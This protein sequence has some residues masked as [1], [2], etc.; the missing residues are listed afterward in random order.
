MHM[1][2]IF[3]DNKTSFFLLAKKTLINK[4]KI[5]IYWLVKVFEIM[6]MLANGF[7][8]TNRNLM[9]LYKRANSSVH[10]VIGTPASA[11]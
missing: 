2:V 11:I 1:S 3:S 7:V 10:I 4:N 5:I 9:N 6:R 8:I